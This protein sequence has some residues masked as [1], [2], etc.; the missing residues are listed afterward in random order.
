MSNLNDAIDQ[1]TCLKLNL[2]TYEYVKQYFPNL[3]EEEIQSVLGGLK[4]TGF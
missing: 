2:N 4:Q 1:K 3:N